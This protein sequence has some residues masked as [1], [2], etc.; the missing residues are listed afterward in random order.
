LNPSVII[1][2]SWAKALLDCLLT[3]S[4]SSLTQL[5][6]LL[7]VALP[8]CDDEDGTTAANL[9]QLVNR[10]HGLAT[11]EQTSTASTTT[12]TVRIN[13]KS[14][15]W[16]LFDAIAKGADMPSFVDWEKDAF[17]VIEGELDWCKTEQGAGADAVARHTAAQHGTGIFHLFLDLLAFSPNSNNTLSE[18]A[19]ARMQHRRLQKQT[20]QTGS[21]DVS[22]QPRRQERNVQVPVPQ[23][24]RVN[25]GSWSEI[26]ELFL[27][28][29]K[30]ACMRYAVW[31][32]RQGLFQ[33]D[34]RA[35]ILSILA[36]TG[37]SRH[38]KVAA[39]YL[40]SLLGGQR[41]IRVGNSLQPPKLPSCSI[42]VA[43]CLLVLMLGDEVAW[44]IVKT[45]PDLHA[46][47]ERILGKAPTQPAL[48]RKPLLPMAENA[49]EYIRENLLLTDTDLSERLLFWISFLPFHMRA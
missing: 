26:E 12:T 7:E 13:L 35:M 34:E 15:S 44:E 36:A 17:S 38:G 19:I 49:L 42:T 2:A 33:D 14:S 1:E 4:Q 40:C 24:R 39:D 21:T 30:L 41:L 28:H 37:S 20:Q 47:Y 3:A 16:M 29:L 43:N 8:A 11:C 48:Q 9:I 27:R 46:C 5:L 10:L 6:P 45:F 31:P 18:K 32:A 25:P 22:Q 23:R